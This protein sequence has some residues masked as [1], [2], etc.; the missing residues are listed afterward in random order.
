MS[1]QPNTSININTVELTGRVTRQPELRLIPPGGAL[2]A[3]IP[4][5]MRA[6]WAGCSG[7]ITA[8][9]YKIPG[10]AQGQLRSAPMDRRRGYRENLPEFRCDD[11]GRHPRV[12][13]RWVSTGRPDS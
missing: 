4:L 12:D 10:F 5:D 3:M 1:Q 8:I 7:D 13:G 9:K 2:Y 11:L 6:A